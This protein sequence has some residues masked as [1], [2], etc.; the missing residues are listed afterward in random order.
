VIPMIGLV[1]MG[2]LAT[3]LTKALDLHNVKGVAFSH[4]YI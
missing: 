3:L 4:P 1:I 2:T